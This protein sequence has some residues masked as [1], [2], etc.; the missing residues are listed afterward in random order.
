MSSLSNVTLT[1]NNR[2]RPA[3][4]GRTRER[5]VLDQLL[6]DIRDQNGTR[7]LVLRGDAGIGKTALLDYL[8]ERADALRV[9]RAVGVQSDME[10]A[11]AGLQQLCGPLL[12]G[13][14]HLPTPQS[15]AIR[16][17]FGL[18]G[19]PAPDP[20]LVALGTLGLLSN[21]AS[22]R[23]VVCVV[24]DA[25]WLDRTSSQILTFVARR[26]QAESV[27]L[28][29]A[30]RHPKQPE[31]FAGL[32]DLVVAGLDFPD[33]REVLW[34]VMTGRLD[35]QVVDRMIAETHGNP[36]ALLELAHALSSHGMAGGFGVLPPPVTAGIEESFLSPLRLLP[37]ETQQ[38]LLVAAAE[39]AGDP[40]LLWR[41]ADQLG[42]AV[43]TAAPAEA[44]G[45]VNLNGR[46]QFCHPLARSAIYRAATREDRQAAHRALAEATD[47]QLDP[48]RRAWH[49]AQAALGPEEAVA[50]E[51]ERSAD[52]ALARGGL[53]AGA[54][55]LE[56]AA[57][58]TPDPSARAQRALGAAERHY[59]AGAPHGAAAL[60]SRVEAWPLDEL[61]RAMFDRLRSRVVLQMR[62]GAEA[63][64]QLLN[65]AERLESLDVH[66]ARETYIDALHAAMLAESPANRATEEVA[67]A[68]RHAPQLAPP[69]TAADRLLAGL[70]VR[71][72]NG[73]VAAAPALKEAIRE[74]RDQGFEAE[75]G[76]RWILLALRT[77]A[78]LF[79]DETWD[80]LATSHVQI[81]RDLGA[82]SVLPLALVDFAYLRIFASDFDSAAALGV[83][84]DVIAEATGNA[85]IAGALELLVAAY[86]DEFR[87]PLL[88]EA[89]RR[90]AATGVGRTPLAYVEYADAMLHNSLGR[91]DI[92]MRSAQ[93]CL[94]QGGLCEATWAIAELIEAATR[95]GM[96]QVASAAL[97]TLSDRTRA[98]GTDWAL[99][100]EAR[101]RALLVE[102]RV[103]DDLYREAIERLT[104]SRVVVELARARLLYGE[105][106]RRERRRIEAREQLRTAHD[107]FS[108]MG[109]HIFAQR[110]RRELLATGECTRRRTVDTPDSLTTQEQQVVRL[111]RAGRSNQEIGSQLFISTKTVEYHL[112]K[113]FAKLGI[114][115][116]HELAHVLAFADGNTVPS[117]RQDKARWKTSNNT[118]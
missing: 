44:V 70:A 20:F 102:G 17:A 3:L 47:P 56:R 31:V 26:L 33:A 87:A 76:L 65:V 42:L 106:L 74:L 19:G 49:R 105:W 116:R 51:L 110:A 85:R 92:A 79:D 77:A 8:V 71:F 16:V 32:P 15:E 73:Y 14:D 50:A 72:T 12:A 23:P 64:P 13:F 75:R 2:R 55:F 45:L 59:L 11:F 25:Q 10:L 9:A 53:A 1:A 90:E 27:G 114:S 115:S 103:A 94:A 43:H 54:A 48:D 22:D 81:A 118:G 4:L 24:D 7:V 95:A 109:A 82:L 35:E 69:R 84:A 98:S 21:A 60:L 52:R 37:D 83:E 80:V 40:A 57:T 91:Y 112:H 61:Q 108:G 93:A 88:I 58:L 63:W 36:R 99:G 67:R 29:F 96:A 38:L 62:G 18:T 117:A 113:A 30:V 68:I 41:A 5:A 78:D 28:I 34:S 101:S 104:R 89:A 39:P 66:L 86:Q 97:Q 107:L 100:I 6:A 111:A 46:V